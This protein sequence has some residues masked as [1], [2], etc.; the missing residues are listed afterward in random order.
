MTQ[1]F[2]FGK[3]SRKIF[4][5]PFLFFRGGSRNGAIARLIVS[6]ATKQLAPAY[7]FL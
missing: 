3:R 5:Y 4:G 7:A 6:I 2:I 1:F